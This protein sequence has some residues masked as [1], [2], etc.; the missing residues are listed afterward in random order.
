MS[1][2]DS[3]LRTIRR[4][5]MLPAGGRVAVALSGGPDSVALLHL[6]RELENRGD[7]VVAGAAHFN[8][9]LRGTA[10]DE[11]EAF[12]RELADQLKI[13]LEVGTRGRAWQGPR[14]EEVDRGR[15]PQRTLRVPGCGR[16]EAEGRR[17]CGRPQSRRSG[18]DVPAQA[19]SR[20]GD[21]RAGIDPAAG[22]HHHSPAA[23]HYPSGT[24]PIR[25]RPRSYLQGRRHQ[26]GRHDPTKPCSTRALALPRAGVHAAYRRGARSR[27]RARP[28]R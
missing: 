6:L 24:P 16:A 15:R 11:D 4:H 12:C 8:H 7:L 26:R 20:L 25:R 19:A 5:D 10:S 17:R 13:P 23:R 22:R 2:T 18:R 27:S 9:Q 1:L 14:G 21:A 28:G 3:V